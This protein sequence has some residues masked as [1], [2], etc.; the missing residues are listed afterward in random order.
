MHVRSIAFFQTPFFQLISA[1]AT[2]LFRPLSG[3]HAEYDQLLP[4]GHSI[5]QHQQRASAMRITNMFLAG[6]AEI[7]N[8]PANDAM[9]SGNAKQVLLTR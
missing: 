4:A 8:E 3:K 1:N 6:P 9:L 2:V 7:G 5:D